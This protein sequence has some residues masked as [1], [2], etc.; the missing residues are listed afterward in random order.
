MS[1]LRDQIMTALAGVYDPEIRRP[2]TDLGMVDAVG[3]DDTGRVTVDVLL[4]VNGCP[5][6]ATLAQDVEAAVKQVDGVTAVDVH[7]GV[8]NDQQRAAMRESLRGETGETPGRFQNPFDTT[9][10]IA[11]ASGKGGVGKSSLTV[12]LAVALAALGKQVGLLDADIYGHSVP[13]MMGVADEHPMVVDDMIMPIPAYGVATMSIGLM[14][15]SRDQV[16]AWRGPML[17]HALGQLLNDVYWG[18]LDFLIVDLPPGTG[19]MPMSVGRQLPGASVLVVTTPNA[20]AYEVAERAGTLAGRMKQP[21]IGVVENMSWLDAECPHCGQSHRVEL[22]G[23]GGGAAAA[24][25]LSMRLGEP[26]PLLA[27]IPLDVA[28]RAGGDDGQPVVI[29]APDSPA[30]VAIKTLAARLV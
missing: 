19:D 22:F 8:M 18:D 16:I 14:K 30:A 3:I 25:A 5:L 28:V 29:A 7:M 13:A 20:A 10:V 1:D 11:V 17:D 9:Q 21:V 2:I 24:D 4:T 27:Q 15:E 6:Q 12:N 26:V 23:S